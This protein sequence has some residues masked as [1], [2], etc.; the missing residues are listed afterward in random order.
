MGMVNISLGTRGQ[1]TKTAVY[2]HGCD[3]IDTVIVLSAPGRHEEDAETPASGQT[4]KTLNGLLEALN[5]RDPISFPSADKDDYRIVNATE[6]V[7]FMERTGR[8]EATTAELEAPQNL[9]RLRAALRDKSI[10]VALG[11]KAQSTLKAAGIA[12]TFTGPHLSLQRINRF[13][14]SQATTRPA[15]VEDRLGQI[16]ETIMNSNARRCVSLG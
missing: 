2:Q 7:H 15:R 4:G 9:E 1:M 12:V 10:V 8:T 14:K 6:T 5:L 3:A 13:Y 11:D 16:A